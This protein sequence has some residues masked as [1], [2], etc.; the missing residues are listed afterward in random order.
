MRVPVEPMG[1][2]FSHTHGQQD[3]HKDFYFLDCA[4]D[5]K[6]VLLDRIAI[7]FADEVVDYFWYLEELQVIK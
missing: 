3:A 4:V 2:Q 5:G 7:C 1:R 6:A